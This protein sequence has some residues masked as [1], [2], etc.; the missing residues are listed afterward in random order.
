MK[1]PKFPFKK[2]GPQTSADRVRTC[3]FLLVLEKRRAR[4]M[5]K[6][7][8]EWSLD[9]YVRHLLLC[10]AQELHP[11]TIIPTERKAPFVEVPI[12]LDDSVVK[13]L[14][15]LHELAPM[16]ELICQVIDLALEKLP[17]KRNVIAPGKG[18]KTTGR[19]L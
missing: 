4:A 12:R 5:K 18:P 2:K 3:P 7:A 13:L 15:P 16:N 8:P 9:R 1:P 10:H 14:R 6:I 17:K 11:R 19:Q